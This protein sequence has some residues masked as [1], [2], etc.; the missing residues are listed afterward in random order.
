[1]EA[2]GLVMVAVMVVCLRHGFPFVFKY[3]WSFLA[4]SF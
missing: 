3:S 4:K 1:M 2:D